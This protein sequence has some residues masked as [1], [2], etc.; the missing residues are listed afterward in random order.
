MVLYALL[1]FMLKAGSEIRL[2]ETVYIIPLQRSIGTLIIMTGG[3]LQEVVHVMVSGS[4]IRITALYV[5]V[6]GL[7]I[8]IKL[9]FR[10][11][12]EP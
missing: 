10:I 12:A 3:I 11:L 5:E 1:R 4:E 9:V 7:I 6:Y 8:A 2:V